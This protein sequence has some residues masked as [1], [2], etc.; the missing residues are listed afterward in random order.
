MGPN[1]I[2]LAVPFFFLLIGIELAVARKRRHA[3]YRFADAISDLGCGIG[4]RIALLFLETLLVAVYI[5]GYE[6]LRIVD[7]GRSPLLAWVVA[8]VAVDFIYYWWHRASHRLNFLW[9]AHVIHHQSEDFNLAVAL[10]QSVLTP[11]TFTP[12]VLPLAMMGIPPL[13]YLAAISLN[14]LYQ[15][16]IHTELIGRLGP[17]EWVLNTPS[18]HRV[19]HARNHRYLDRNYAAVF[20]IWD[21]LFGTFEPE[22]ETPRYGITRP[23]RSFN[24]LWAQVQPL[25]ELTAL[26]RTAPSWRDRLRVWLAPPERHF[27][28]GAPAPADSG[29]KYDVAVAPGLRR[30]VLVN[31]ALAVVTTFLLMMFGSTLSVAQ[32]IAGSALV[33]ATVLTTGGLMENRRWARPLE[34]ARLI[35][36]VVTLVAFVSG[37]I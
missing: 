25:A 18:H 36:T 33:L 15:F 26:S 28:W 17:L 21:R 2:A 1:Y 30:Y 22:R 13:V 12:F 9:A 20:I 32:L 5:A 14:T 34:A 27:D 29:G 24:P 8:F 11:L 19:H 3:T 10:R 4:Q 35:A 16:W 6:R 23:L 37:P 7:L 31:F